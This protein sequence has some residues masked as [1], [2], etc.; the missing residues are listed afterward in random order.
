MS[1]V[2]IIDLASSFT[3]DANARRAVAAEIGRACESI[4]FLMVTGHGVPQGLID[5]ADGL[6]RAFFDLPL[7]EKMRIA[8]AKQ[9]GRRGYRA[10]GETNVA[11]SIGE[12]RPYDLRE[13]LVTGPTAPEGDPYY[14]Q[15]GALPFFY[16]NVWPERPAR[17]K[18]SWGAYYAAMTGLATHIMRLFALALDLPE[19]YF[20]N[21]VDRHIT[22][23]VSV[24][25]PA[26]ATPPR[27]G[28]LRAGAHSD[29]G[30]VTLLATDGS[31]GGLQVKM[32][33]GAWHDIM[34]VKGAYIVNL[35]DLMA[36]WTN[37]LWCST[38]HRVVTPPLELAASSRRHSMVFFHQPN[39]DAL[40]EC[41]PT[42]LAPGERPKYAPVTSGA[43]LHAQLAK[44]YV[45]PPR[46]SDL[47]PA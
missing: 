28:Q 36:Q 40:I 46:Q 5:E 3:G 38:M 4:G 29:F 37:D 34:P 42:C 17:L 7:E 16:P 44:I 30:S 19:S 1:A 6:S 10:M 18:H 13:Q 32:A 9:G 20:D 2:P 26:T 24:N 33:D 45:K 22:Q 11:G 14:R 43:H 27:P 25:Y 39:Y 47:V 21:K 23:L 8:I 12:E 35:G 41:L 31:P 15:P